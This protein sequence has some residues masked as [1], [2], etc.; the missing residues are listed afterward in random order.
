MSQAQYDLSTKTDYLNRKMFLDP[1][2]WK[3]LNNPEAVAPSK[4]LT[5]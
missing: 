4:S 2:G 5:M 1:A 3:Y